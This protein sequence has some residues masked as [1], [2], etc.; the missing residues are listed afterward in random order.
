[1]L[2]L[3]HKCFAEAKSPEWQREFK[4]IIPSFGKS[5]SKEKDLATKTRAWTTEV[6]HLSASHLEEEVTA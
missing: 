4:K 3:I 6:L 1:M 2:E 5:L